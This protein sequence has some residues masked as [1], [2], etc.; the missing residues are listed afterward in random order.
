LKQA[1]LLVRAAGCLIV[2]LFLLR[3]HLVPLGGVP[4]TGPGSDH[5]LLAWNFWWVT[6]SVLQ[7]RNPYRTTLLFHPLGSSLAAHTLGPGFV[8]VGLL[9]RAALHGDAAYPLHALRLSIGLCFALGM[10]LACEALRALG[11]ASFPAFAA[12]T[13]WAFAAFWRPLVGNPTLASACFLVPAV[14]LAIAGLVKAPSVPRAILLGALVGGSVYFSEYFSAFIVAALV[15]AGV[16]ALAGADSRARVLAVT[17]ITGAH[18]AALALAACLLVAAPFLINWARTQGRPPGERQIEAGGANL[19]GFVVPY[20]GMTPVYRSPVVARLYARVTRGRGPFLGFPTLLLAALGTCTSDRR[21]RR[22]LL[23]VAVVFVVL[24][25]GPSLKVLGS[26][27][28][29]PLPYDALRHVPPFQMARDPQRL[30]VFAVW[31]LVILAALGLTAGA[32]AVARRTR[33]A[34]GAA[35]AAVALAWWAAEG[36]WPQPRPVAYAPPPE[37]RGLPPGAVANLP[38]NLRDGYAMFL[39]VFHGRPIVTGYVSRA[40]PEQY[41]HV[42]R[43]QAVLDDDPAAFAA[44]LRRMGVATV[45]LGPGTPEPVAQALPGHDLVVLDRRDDARSP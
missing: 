11:A 39:Q 44:E 16:A 23:A 30:A 2:T 25:L 8:P 41:T 13:G 33:P 35:L 32:G 15:V 43:L 34:F 1:G 20:P 36:Y 6:E 12:A 45:I 4:A 27:A 26:R 3:T 22:V 18:G 28:S 21:L 24:S 31:A 40:S 7:G 9:A 38:L 19:A 17:R 37:L 14:T 10:F 29:V 42:E 5:G